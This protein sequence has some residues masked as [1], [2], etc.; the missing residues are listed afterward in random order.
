[1]ACERCSA[2]GGVVMQ[3]KGR[4]GVIFSVFSSIFQQLLV[5]GREIG[6][7][8]GNGIRKRKMVLQRVGGSEWS[9]CGL[10]VLE[11]RAYV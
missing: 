11:N 10:A 2:R 9:A 7:L 4:Q 8:R 5:E 6:M 1:M 3:G